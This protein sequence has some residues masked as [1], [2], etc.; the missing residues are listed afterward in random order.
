MAWGHQ[1]AGEPPHLSS[2]L[3]ACLPLIQSRLVQ[4]YELIISQH[5]SFQSSFHKRFGQ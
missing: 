5:R 1:A 3:Y 4:Y 2:S